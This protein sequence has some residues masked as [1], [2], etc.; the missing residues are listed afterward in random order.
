M[1]ERGKRIK[2]IFEKSVSSNLKDWE[3]TQKSQNE[4]KEKLKV[5][6]DKSF[7]VYMK[8]QCKEGYEWI[9]KY[10]IIKMNEDGFNF[11]VQEVPFGEDP[12]EFKDKFQNCAK[13]FKF[14]LDEKIMEIRTE[15]TNTMNKYNNCVSSCIKSFD[16]MTDLDLK[17]CFNRC[18]K[19]TINTT[20]KTNKKLDYMVNENMNKLKK[21]I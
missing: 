15:Y 12:K 8:D 19:E 3:E 1:E 21:Y 18:F 11:S 10:G 9:E 6:R 13:T 17:N 20:E 7:L 2:D 16:K 5:L 14:N 4:I